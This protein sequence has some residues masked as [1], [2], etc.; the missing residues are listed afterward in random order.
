MSILDLNFQDVY[1]PELI[2]DGTEI[3]LTIRSA[4]Q[5]RTKSGKNAM[6]N[7]VLYDASNP[8]TAPFTER[9]VVP[10]DTDKADDLAKWNNGMRRIQNFLKC[11]DLPST[12]VDPAEA[13]PGATGTVIVREEEDETYG[14]KNSVRKFVVGH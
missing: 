9:L 13:F 8:K 5:V 14:K 12:G 2:P 6:L 4:E 10:S 3:T 11:F 7:V 1:E